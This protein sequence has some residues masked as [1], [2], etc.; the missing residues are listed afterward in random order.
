[1]CAHAE[2]IGTLHCV[3]HHHRQRKNYNPKSMKTSAHEDTLDSLVLP[4]HLLDR[5]LDISVMLKTGVEHLYQLRSRGSE[6]QKASHQQ[7]KKWKHHPRLQSR[8]RS[9]SPS[10]ARDDFHQR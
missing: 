6:K 3:E 5:W 7:K 1:M 8:H 9:S 4:T 2:I 10:K